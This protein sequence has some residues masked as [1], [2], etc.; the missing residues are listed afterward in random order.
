MLPS[1]LILAV[2]SIAG[3]LATTAVRAEEIRDVEER[4]AMYLDKS[5]KVQIVTINEKGHA[6]MMHY[7]RPLKD[8]AMIY[9]SGGKFYVLE[10]RKMANG[11][12]LYSSMSSW[13]NDRLLLGHN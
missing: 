3:V 13:T 2:A 7:G 4:H 6:M 10:D 9:R 1:K 12:M 11:Q 8:G 5:G